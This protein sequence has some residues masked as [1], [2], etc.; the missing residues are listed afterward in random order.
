MALHP[1]VVYLGS[2]TWAA[3]GSIKLGISP[4]PYAIT[5]LFCVLSVNVTTGA[6]AGTYDDPLDRVISQLSINKG[7]KQPFAYTDMRAAYYHQV[8]KLRQFAPRRP[9]AP[10]NSQ[11]NV[12]ILV[13]YLF[14]FGVKPIES[15]GEGPVLNHFDM[16]GGIPPSAIGDMS[17]QGLWGG[18]AAPGSGWTVNSG[19]LFV[20]ACVLRA[21]QD[22]DPG[23]QPAA[24]PRWDMTTL[25]PAA[26]SAS[27]TQ[28]YDVPQSGFLKSLMLLSY[29]GSNSPRSNGVLN[30]WKL[31][32]F[33]NGADIAIWQNYVDGEI[34]GQSEM[35]ALP[36]ADDPATPG[37]PSIND[38]DVT[39]LAYVNLRQYAKNSA[40]PN[41]GLD[42]RA[43]ASNSLQVQYGVAN[44]T[45]ASVVVVHERYDLND[46]HPLAP[47]AATG[48]VKH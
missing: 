29:Q 22:G 9:A 37:T 14:H 35:G 16:T 46:A 32:D 18:A 13:P 2:Q 19:T 4:T 28:P 27:Y 23:L 21:D 3:N 31:R 26:T 42:M 45:N 7:G 36:P 40:Q 38:V 12:T 30:G 48:A 33:K 20:Y 6:S 44:A 10:G 15:S 34:F 24:L 8:N 47:L 11:S 39:G 5:E 41:Y 17:L 43:A 1:A 25:T